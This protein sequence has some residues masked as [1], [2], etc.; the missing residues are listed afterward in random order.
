[1]WHV[2]TGEILVI[3]AEAKTFNDHSG[4]ERD[5]QKHRMQRTIVYPKGQLLNTRGYEP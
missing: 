3:T 1:M 5:F 2:I 4:F